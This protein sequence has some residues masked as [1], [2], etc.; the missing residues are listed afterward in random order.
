MYNMSFV[1][2]SQIMQNY[3]LLSAY[4]LKPY[5]TYL[6]VFCS[7]QY[8]QNTFCISCISAMTQG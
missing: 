1:L 8:V 5:W 7:M 2:V 3:N 6:Q 4:L